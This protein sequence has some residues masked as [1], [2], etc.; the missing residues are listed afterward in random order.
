MCRGSAVLLKY[1]YL[2]IIATQEDPKQHCPC[3][4][5][6]CFLNCTCLRQIGRQALCEIAKVQT[7]TLNALNKP[8]STKGTKGRSTWHFLS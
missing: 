4:Q 5:P 3:H 7:A 8:Y 1:N 2:L 6:N